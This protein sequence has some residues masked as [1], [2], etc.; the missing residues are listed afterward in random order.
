MLNLF[1]STSF[2]DYLTHNWRVSSPISGVSVCRGPP[3]GGQVGAAGMSERGGDGSGQSMR[4]G[5][6]H[7][8]VGVPPSLI[9]LITHSFAVSLL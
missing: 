7:L 2:R 4:E 1:L 8:R 5:E 3:R 6:H 9:S